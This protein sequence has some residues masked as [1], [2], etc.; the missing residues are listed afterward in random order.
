[1]THINP[2]AKIE[3]N[4]HGGLKG[5]NL[6]SMVTILFL[7]KSENPLTAKIIWPGDDEFC[8]LI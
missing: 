4:L 5:L 8:G 3:Q 6:V 1:M 7:G 2:L